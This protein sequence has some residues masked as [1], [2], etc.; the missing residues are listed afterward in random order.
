M[1]RIGTTSSK[2]INEEGKI[3]GAIGMRNEMAGKITNNS[4]LETKCEAAIRDG[5][6][7]EKSGKGKFF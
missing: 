4:R 7:Q 2:K 6:N 3:R 1:R 5:T